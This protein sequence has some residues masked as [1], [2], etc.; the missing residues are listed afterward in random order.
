MVVQCSFAPSES[1]KYFCRNPCEDNLAET[2]S[3]KVQKGRYSIEFI[4][5]NSAAFLYVSISQLDTSDSGQYRC[6]VG[7]PPTYVYIEFELVV[8]GGEFPV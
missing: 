1:R 3:E 4:Q 7:T 5:G 6:I 2:D 8:R